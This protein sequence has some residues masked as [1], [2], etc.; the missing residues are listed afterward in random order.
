M[1]STLLVTRVPGAAAPILRAL[2][3]QLPRSAT[4]SGGR[5]RRA[6][7]RQDYYPVSYRYTRLD[8][9]LP[10]GLD[11]AADPTQ[12]QALSAARDSGRP[13]ATEPLPLPESGQPGLILFLPIY[14]QGAPVAT[15]AQ[16]RRAINA[17]VASALEARQ[18]GRTFRRCVPRARSPRSSTAAA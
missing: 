10:I 2:A 1:G 9:T 3:R 8:R 4:E 5:L 13:Q 6:P 12:G 18:L 15:A 16:R 17:L 14:R 7:A 11:L